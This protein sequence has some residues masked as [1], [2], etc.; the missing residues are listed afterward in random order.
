MEPHKIIL[1]KQVQQSPE[2]RAN[3][4]LVL[5]PLKNKWS[6]HE[7]DEMDFNANVNGWF[8]GCSVDA[9][10]TP[11]KQWISFWQRIEWR[12]RHYPPEALTF[13]DSDLLGCDLCDGSVKI[14][15][16]DKLYDEYGDGHHKLDGTNG[17]SDRWFLYRYS[18]RQT[19]DGETNPSALIICDLC[20]KNLKKKLKR[21]K[22][23]TKERLI[24]YTCDTAFHFSTNKRKLNEIN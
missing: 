7:F 22:K 6:D 3:Y 16:T 8:D 23:E 13:E 19:C 2:Y 24:T 20:Y 1:T 21:Y 17:V 10:N 9:D 12:F 15:K 14:D 11:D 18:V 4:Q 5:P